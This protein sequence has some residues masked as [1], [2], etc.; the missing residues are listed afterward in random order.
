VRDILTL[1]PACRL[2][3]PRAIAEQAGWQPGER[4][5]PLVNGRNVTLVPLRPLEQ[6]YG[7]AA[8]AQI[9]PIEDDDDRY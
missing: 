1:T 4:L 7:I 5:V 9:G 8:G 2:T 3:I 6:L